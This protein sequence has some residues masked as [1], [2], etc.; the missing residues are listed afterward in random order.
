MPHGEFP[1][2]PA[3]PRRRLPSLQQRPKKRLH[4]LSQFCRFEAIDDSLAQSGRGKP[5]LIEKIVIR[6]GL[7]PSIFNTESNHSF[8][9]VLGEDFSHQTSKAPEHGVL[10]YSEDDPHR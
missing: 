6:S 1:R 4:F 2:R 8:W 7:T 10:L 3:A 9:K 5:K